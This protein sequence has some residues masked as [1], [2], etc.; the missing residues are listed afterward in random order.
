MHS[1]KALATIL[2]SSFALAA[3]HI[4]VTIENLDPDYDLKCGKTTVKGRDVYNA[5][6]YAVSFNQQGETVTG[7]QGS[8]YP[9]YFG[10]SPGFEWVSKECNNPDDGGNNNLRELFPVISNG[11]FDTDQRPGSFRAVYY[12][13]DSDNDAEGHPKAFYCGTIYHPNSSNDFTGCDVGVAT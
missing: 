3:E 2:L 5:V 8:A 4:P 6:A 11:F 13:N 12:W 7:T 1:F 9:H 10:N